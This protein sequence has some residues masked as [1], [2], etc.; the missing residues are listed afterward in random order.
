MLSAKQANR[1]YFRQ[2]YS[3]GK[4][5]WASV[6]PSSYAVRFLRRLSRLVKEGRLLDLGCGEGRHAIAAARLGFEVTAIDYEPLALRRARALAKGAGVR[7]VSFRKADAL[8][9]PFPKASFDVVLD[10]G[11]LHHQKKEDW[12]AYLRGVLRV[13]RP[14]GFLVLSVFSPRFYM[15][16]DSRRRWHIAQGAYRRCF[17]PQDLR[18]LFSRDFEVLKLVEDKAGGGGFWHAMTRRRAHR[19]RG[20]AQAL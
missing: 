7:G 20:H 14:R 6:R 3:S 4:H 11:C 1:R 5:G 12:P 10:Y 15:F 18:R 8:H 16:K 17:A 2:A 9:L 13:L 19:R